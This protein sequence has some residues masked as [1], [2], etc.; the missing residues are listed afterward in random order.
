MKF[1]TFLRV[2]SCVLN[3]ILEVSLLFRVLEY[4]R[5]IIFSHGPK[6]EESRLPFQLN[7]PLFK[8]FKFLFSCLR[9]S[10]ILI[11]FYLRLL[12]LKK[13]LTFFISIR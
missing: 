9:I 7:I 2:N 12:K 5:S 10:N 1:S 11:P 6:I 13:T 3:A 4:Q 8:G